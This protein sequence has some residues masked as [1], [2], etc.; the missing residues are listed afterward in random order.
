MSLHRSLK[1]SQA[2]ATSRN[3]LKRFERIRRMMDT[4]TWTEG[5]S[6]FALPK[7]KQLRIKARK[8]AAK[9]A[10]ETAAAQPGAE[11]GATPT[12]SS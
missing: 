5:R 3:V 7:L 11:A 2:S 4:G 10:T 12:P 6:V 1:T 9:E 8:A